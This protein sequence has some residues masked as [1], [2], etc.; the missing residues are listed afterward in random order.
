MAII[1]DGKALAAKMQDHLHEKV[2]RLKEKEW[3]VPGLVVIMVGDNPASQV[4]VRNKERAAKKAGFHSK[5]VNLSESIS[6]EELIEVIEQYNQD[7]LFHG[8][9]V[10]LPLPNHINEMRILLAI[11]PKKDVDGFHMNTGNLWNGRRQMVPCT[12]AGIME[13]LREYNVELEGKTAVIIGRSNIVGKPMAQLLL[14]KNATVTLTHSRTPHLA[15]VCSK[16]DVLIV[17]IGRAKFVQEFR[18]V[19]R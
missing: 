15:K 16:A 18:I 4:Y 3:I 2:E 9:L 13:I 14:E 6:E 5:T 11:D 1:M 19:E 7:P 17:A 12:P 10:Q 8:I